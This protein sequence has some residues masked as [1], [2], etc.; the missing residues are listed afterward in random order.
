MQYRPAL[1][2]EYRSKAVVALNGPVSF[3]TVARS[4]ATSSCHAPIA[5]VPVSCAAILQEKSRSRVRAALLFQISSTGLASLKEPL[6]LS[7]RAT[8]SRRMKAA[9]N[10]IKSRHQLVKTVTRPLCREK[11]SFCTT[12]IPANTSMIYS[13]LV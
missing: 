7:P 2:R 4:S 6:L 11:A 5:P 12:A 1:G 10:L 13:S 9:P 8:T 3:A